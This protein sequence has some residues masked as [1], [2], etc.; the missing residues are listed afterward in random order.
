MY[1][2]EVMNKILQSR[3]FNEG[4]LQEKML[5]NLRY[6]MKN[7]GDRFVPVSMRLTEFDMG[8]K[9]NDKFLLWFSPKNEGSILLYEDQDVS[10]KKMLKTILQLKPTIGGQEC[11][12]LGTIEDDDLH[13]NNYK[14][15]AWSLLQQDLY[16]SVWPSGLNPI[17]ILL[18]KL[19][20]SLR[21]IRNPLPFLSSYNIIEE[22]HN[23]CASSRHVWNDMKDQLKNM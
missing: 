8:D 10:Q 19:R 4:R 21:K 14:L 23:A 18:R 9:T 3:P 1:N 22:W 20:I 13:T 6:V 15:N 16:R 7:D 17:S 5:F 12:I 11:K 2:Q